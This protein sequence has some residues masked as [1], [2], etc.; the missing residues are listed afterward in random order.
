MVAA[1]L[2]KPLDKTMRM[3][4]WSKR[5]LTAQQREYAALDAW[6]LVEAHRSLL[7]SHADRYIALVDQVNKSYE[8][9]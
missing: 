3:S 9:K 4:D 7:A 2:G 6:T 8:F 5:P 1:V